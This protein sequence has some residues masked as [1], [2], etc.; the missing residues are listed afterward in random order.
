MQQGLCAPA[1]AATN[2]IL[3]YFF[4]FSLSYLHIPHGANCCKQEAILPFL[5]AYRVRPLWPPSLIKL[6]DASVPQWPPLITDLMGL[7]F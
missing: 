7:S 3:F 2:H 4:N 6:L 5:R 1:I